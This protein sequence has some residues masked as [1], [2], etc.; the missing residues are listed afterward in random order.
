MATAVI[1][2]AVR[3]PIGK[4]KATGA[5]HDVHPVDLLAHSLRAVVERTGIDPAEIDDVITG[6]VTQGGEQ[7]LNI[8][9]RGLLAAGYP[10]SVPGVSVDRQC[11][12]GQQAIAFAA[13]AVAS[14]AADV[15]VAAGVESMS[16]VSMGSATFGAADLNGVA[17]PRASS[18]SPSGCAA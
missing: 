8:A 15:V 14:G 5:L 13:Q 10:E 6:V 18:W 17:P 2:D 11:G 7:S 3:T 4:G 12:S 9:R 16:R 1:V